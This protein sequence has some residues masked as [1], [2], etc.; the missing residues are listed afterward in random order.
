MCIPCT[1]PVAIVGLHPPLIQSLTAPQ[2]PL[3]LGHPLQVPA[4]ETVL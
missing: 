4:V 3:E 2:E 1:Y